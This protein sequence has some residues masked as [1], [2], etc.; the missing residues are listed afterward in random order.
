MMFLTTQNG[1][2]NKSFS[3]FVKNFDLFM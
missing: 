3:L 2:L 1:F